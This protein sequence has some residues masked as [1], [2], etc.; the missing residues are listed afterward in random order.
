VTQPSQDQTHREQ[1]K[2]TGIGIEQYATRLYRYFLRQMRST[3]DAEDLLQTVYMRWWQSPKHELVQKPESYLYRIASNVL[4]EYRMRGRRDVV[5]YDS[6]AAEER[7]ERAEED[8][9]WRDEQTERAALEQQLR[10]VLAQIP[11]TYRAAL[12]MRTR[13]DLSFDEIGKTLGISTKAAKTYVARAL[14]ACRLADWN[15]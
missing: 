6:D 3:Q 7:A 5:I 8:E 10:R 14:A 12:V 4:A 11:P 9:L 15:R 2:P 1:A 13:D